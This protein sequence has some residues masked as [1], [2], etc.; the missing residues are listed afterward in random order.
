MTVFRSRVRRKWR[1]HE[2]VNRRLLDYTG[3]LPLA[4]GNY[5]FVY[6]QWEVWGPPKIGETATQYMQYVR[7]NGR[8]LKQYPKIVEV[9]P[10]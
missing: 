6:E 4:P 9:E 8:I 2:F 7:A 3:R 10:D 1:R 5:N